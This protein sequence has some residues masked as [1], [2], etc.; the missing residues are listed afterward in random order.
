MNELEAKARRIDGLWEQVALSTP[1]LE[2]VALKDT[3]ESLRH[4]STRYDHRYFAHEIPCD[5]DYPL[6]HPVPETMLGVEYVIEYLERLLVENDF[7]QRFDLARCKALLN[8]VHPDY[9]ELIINLYEPV[10]V[11]ALGCA[12]AGKEVRELN[13]TEDDRAHIAAALAGCSQSAVA[14][15]LEDAARAVCSAMGIEDERARRYLGRTAQN[16]VP[17]IHRFTR[18]D[19][20]R[21]SLAGV[22]LTF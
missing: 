18:S 22:F 16:A 12:L 20:R 4:F 1:L 9:R 21:T 2:S 10:A 3:L 6:A 14:S 8:A 13:V 15:K 5:I 19:S 7:M 11:N 17:R